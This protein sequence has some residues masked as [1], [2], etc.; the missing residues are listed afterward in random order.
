M[1][2]FFPVALSQ[3]NPVP[4]KIDWLARLPLLDSVVE[5]RIFMVGY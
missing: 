5:N 4:P 2:E 3:V 1:P